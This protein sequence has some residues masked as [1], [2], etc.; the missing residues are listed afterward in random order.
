MTLPFEEKQTLHNVREFLRAI[1]Q[2]RV[3]DI[4]SQ[5]SGIRDKAGQLLRHYPMEYRLDE[6][7]K[8]EKD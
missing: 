7:Y 1:I 5:A 3:T 4:R 6:L 2:L 8:D